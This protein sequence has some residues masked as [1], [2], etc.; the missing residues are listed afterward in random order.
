MLR[1]LE[2]SDYDKGFPAILSQLTTV[3]AVSRELFLQR[4]ASMFGT[5]VSCGAHARSAG[6]DAATVTGNAAG[7]A[8]S[9]EEEA[10]RKQHHGLT[11]FFS[12][13]ASS[14]SPSSSSS[15]AFSIPSST[16]TNVFVFEDT[17]KGV[18]IGAGTLLVENKF[19]HACGRVGHVEDIVVDKAYRGYKLGAMYVSF[20]L[21]RLC[22]RLL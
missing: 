17:N 18:V 9:D 2:P 1:R 21:F 16:S 4:F 19:I 11:E 8:G 6:T 13:S 5:G 7:A 20:S 3:G 22:S 10:E 15:S 12:S 14:S